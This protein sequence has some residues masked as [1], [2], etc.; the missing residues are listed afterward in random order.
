MTCVNCETDA[1][2]YTLRAHVM[3]SNG[4]IDL[5]FCSTDCLREWV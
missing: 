4:E 2:A 3:E 1:T 5:P